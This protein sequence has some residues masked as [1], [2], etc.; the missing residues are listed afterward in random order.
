MV[1]HGS[2]WPSSGCRPVSAWA[3]PTGNRV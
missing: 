3:R 1:T 2:I